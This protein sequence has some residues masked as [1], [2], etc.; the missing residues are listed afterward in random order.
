MPNSSANDFITNCVELKYEAL[1]M[2]K[3]KVT[4][5]LKQIT[6]MTTI[7]NYCYSDSF[8]CFIRLAMNLLRSFSSLQRNLI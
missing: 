4:A 3:K 1:K 8:T 6:T 5:K 7:I 2:R